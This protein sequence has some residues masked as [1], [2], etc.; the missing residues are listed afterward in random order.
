MRQFLWC[1]LKKVGYLVLF[2]C[3]WCF[4]DVLMRTGIDAAEGQV[5]PSL[6]LFPA[7]GLSSR[8]SVYNAEEAQ[9]SWLYLGRASQVCVAPLFVANRG[10]CPGLAG[11]WAVPGPKPG[12]H[13]SRARAHENRGAFCG[14]GSRGCHSKLGEGFLQRPS[15]G[16]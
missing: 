8:L 9:G 16:G 11:G 6:W 5:M 1:W 15:A 7:A 2:G 4:R 12:C 14:N 3:L 10:R 13:L